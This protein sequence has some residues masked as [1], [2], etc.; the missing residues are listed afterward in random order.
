MSVLRL[1]AVAA[2]LVVGCDSLRPPA[3]L[4]PPPEIDATLPPGFPPPLEPDGGTP[5]ELVELGRHLFYDVRLSGNGTFSCAS[6]HRQ[7]LAFTDGRA[8]AV[9]S[10]GELHPRSTMS[11]ANV[12]YNATYTW[13]DPDLTTL[14]EQALVPMLNEHPVELGVAGREDEIVDR[15]ARDSWYAERFQRLFPKQRPGLTVF[16]RALAA[17]Q[18]TLI[19]GGS[20]YDRFV[21]GGD[22]DALTAAARRG[23][24]LFHSERLACSQCHDGF[25]LS[26][27]VQHRG[28]PSSEA[29]FHN[30]GLYNIGGR[31]LYPHTDLGLHKVTGRKKHIGRFRAPTLR[32]IAVTA[33]YMHDGSIA[34]LDEVID[35]YAAGGRTIQAGRAAGVGR[36]NRYKSELVKGFELFADERRDLLELL[37]SFTDEAFLSDPRF[38]DPFSSKPDSS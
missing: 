24:R 30:T 3:V 25:N 7:E 11:L 37:N 10:T 36:D 6:C 34:T 22:P 4:G 21:Y 17:F 12:V 32:N 23:M 13:A 33:P 15:F 38:S 31:G 35:H 5:P 19:S 27:P 9:G 20:P 28:A 29:A 26:G 1:L 16:A 18:R 8:R 14:E 2:V